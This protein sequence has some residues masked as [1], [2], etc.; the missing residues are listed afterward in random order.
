M[1]STIRNRG[2]ITTF[3]AVCVIII[4][5]IAGFFAYQNQ[6]LT[7]QIKELT[8]PTVSPTQ[9]PTPEPTEE[10]LQ[11][12]SPSASPKNQTKAEK[13]LASV[14]CTGEKPCMANPAAVFCTCMSGK[15]TIKTAVDGSQSGVC[16]ISGKTYDEWEYFRSFNKEATTLPKDL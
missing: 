5:I 6:K 9:A 14:T 13:C 4:S 15:S 10:P 11:S 16:T 8:K 1:K 12:A 2:S 3:F 7:A